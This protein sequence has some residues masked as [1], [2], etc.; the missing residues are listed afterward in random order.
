MDVN[1]YD[2]Q[3]DNIDVDDIATNSNNRIVM[4]RIKR[5]EAND[6]DEKGPGSASSHQANPPTQPNKPNQANPRNQPN[7]LSPTFWCIYG[8]VLIF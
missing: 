2:A 3:A 7:Q 6:D 4:R 1:V 5:N 8:W